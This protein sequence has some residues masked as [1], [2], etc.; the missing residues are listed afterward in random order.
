MNIYA[1]SKKEISEYIH[2]IIIKF[3]LISITGP[4]VEGGKF[5]DLKSEYM[6]DRLFLRISDTKRI[7]WKKTEDSC[8]CD[9]EMVKKIYD[10]CKKYENEVDYLIVQC[11]SGISRSAGLAA[12]L[13]KYYN[14]DDKVFFHSLRYIPNMDVYN[15]IL[16]YF[17]EQKNE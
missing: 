7:G 2:S 13:S 17:M 3:I 5:I 15:P 11:D 16:K 10:F 4:E 8:Y 1:F 9:E 12:A 6:V 14:N